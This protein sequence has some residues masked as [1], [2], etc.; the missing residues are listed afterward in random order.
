MI[1]LKKI[2]NIYELMEDYTSPYAN[3][4]A[5][6]GYK[7]DGAS[8]PRF[9]KWFLNNDI[10]G[11]LE[12]SCI[13]DFCYTDTHDDCIYS[14]NR[15]EADLLFKNS[16]KHSKVN[17]FRVYGSFVILRM[18]GWIQWKTPEVKE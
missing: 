2:G 1:V 4:T 15:Y 13:H 6:K 16:L 8:T 18:F 5:P 10:P 11:V 14:K 7:F 17:W 3:V 9:A 12:A